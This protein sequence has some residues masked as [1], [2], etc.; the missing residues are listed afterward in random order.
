MAPIG[1][2]YQQLFMPM[3]RHAQKSSDPPPCLRFEGV[4]Q[5][6]NDSRI[7][8][9]FICIIIHRVNLVQAVQGHHWRRRGKHTMGLLFSS[10]KWQ[11]SNEIEWNIFHTIQFYLALNS[12]FRIL[13]NQTLV[14][15]IIILLL[16][17]DKSS[18]CN[19]VLLQK[20][21]N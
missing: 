21:V 15:W 10:R 7:H 14:I 5:I 1:Q 3:R 18:E 9:L 17:E 19:T 12:C 4:I 11:Q 13:K 20:L 2:V 16:S 6:K 8:Y